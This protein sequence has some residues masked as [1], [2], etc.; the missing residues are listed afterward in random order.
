[1]RNSVISA[2]EIVTYDVTKQAL[3]HKAGMEEGLTAHFVAAMTAGE[4]SSK[5]PCRCISLLY[6]CEA[7]FSLES[8]AQARYKCHW[9]HV[10]QVQLVQVLNHTK[11]LS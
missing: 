10:R 7:S 8:L 11:D 4:R 1:M 3:L 6:R 9:R 2:T 5:P